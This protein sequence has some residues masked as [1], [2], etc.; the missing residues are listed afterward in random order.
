MHNAQDILHSN[1]KI[2]SS[3]FTEAQ[4]YTLSGGQDLQTLINYCNLHK[5]C[6]LKPL[7]NVALWKAAMANYTE[8][9]KFLI[10]L[11]ADVFSQG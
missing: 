6:L 2:T 1:R 11:G 5:H 3:T 9:I 10:Q 4:L 8:N 7:L